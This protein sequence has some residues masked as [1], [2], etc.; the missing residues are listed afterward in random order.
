MMLEVPPVP[1]LSADGLAATALQVFH[2][3]GFSDEQLEG[4]GW[5]G[6]YV[7]KGVKQKII[8]RMEMEGWSKEELEEWLTEVWEP[9]HQLELVTK[10]VKEDNPLAWLNDHIQIL[11]D[12]ANILGLGKGLEQSIEAAEEVGEKLYKLKGMSG[13]R[14]S[15][16]FEGSIKNFTLRLE[17]NVAALR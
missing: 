6:E 12:T 7:K 3:A 9:A 4:V 1:V 16:Y 13:T 5:D 11:N 8:D 17:T 10:D 15:A 14:F 2:E